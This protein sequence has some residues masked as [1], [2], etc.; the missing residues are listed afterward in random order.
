MAAVTFCAS[1]A[2]GHA[3]AVILQNIDGVLGGD[4][5]NGQGQNVGRFVTAV[6]DD[7]DRK[8]VV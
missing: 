3:D 2:G 6:D 1:R 8:S 5:G 7:A 4:T